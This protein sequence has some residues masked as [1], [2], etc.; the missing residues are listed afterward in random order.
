MDTIAAIHSIKNLPQL[1]NIGWDASDVLTL[2]H[3]GTTGLSGGTSVLRRTKG[4]IHSPSLTRDENATELLTPSLAEYRPLIASVA[5]SEPYQ[6]RHEPLTPIPEQA[7]S[8]DLASQI[9]LSCDSTNSLALSS[10][11]SAIHFVDEASG[12][13]I[14]RIQRASGS[15]I[16]AEQFALEPSSLRSSVSL[17]IGSPPSCAATD[18]DAHIESL[19]SFVLTLPTPVSP[20]LPIFS[21][22]IYFTTKPLNAAEAAA[23]GD[24]VSSLPQCDHAPSDAAGTAVSSPSGVGLRLA[25]CWDD[26]G[27]HV[28]DDEDDD[29]EDPGLL[30]IE[31]PPPRSSG[32]ALLLSQRVKAILRKNYNDNVLT[33]A[34]HKFQVYFLQ[35]YRQSTTAASVIWV[36]CSRKLRRKEVKGN[37][38]FLFCAG[39]SYMRVTTLRL[40]GL[41]CGFSQ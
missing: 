23:P 36:V 3:Q 31:A 19:P 22:E 16:S 28:Q 21:P 1:S 37:T 18:I 39:Y 4:T 33:C 17:H 32:L 34:M 12:I 6:S 29:I 5:L 13:V 11:D 9:P 8:P 15:R 24:P 26:E 7:D 14:S 10:A 41:I 2:E 20:P 30:A 27:G 25:E 38:F 35:I 40:I